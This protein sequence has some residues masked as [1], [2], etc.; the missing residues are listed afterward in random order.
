MSD[1]FKKGLAIGLA[2]TSVIGA[3][4]SWVIGKQEKT[5]ERYKKSFEVM[6]KV[7]E[8][9]EKHVEVDVARAILDKYRFDSIV[10]RNFM[11]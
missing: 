11:K 2:A 6:G 8:E 4:G 5:I 3:V 7:A 10:I 9:F 1:D